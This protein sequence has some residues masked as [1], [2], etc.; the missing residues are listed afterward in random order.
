MSFASALA[1]SFNNLMTK[2][3]RTFLTAF[4]GSIGIIGIA[5]ILSLSDGTQNYIADTEESTMGSY[6]LTI[7]ATSMDMA[8]MMTSMMGTSDELSAPNESGAIESKD[9]ITDMVS[10]VAKWCDGKTTWRPSRR[11]STRTRATSRAS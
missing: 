4:A 7:N 1:L 9:L 6:P 8:S 10:G 11:G 2:K 5:L 3:G